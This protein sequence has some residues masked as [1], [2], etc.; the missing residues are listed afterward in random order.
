MRWRT[1]LSVVALVLVFAPTW[2]GEERLALLGRDAV[3][4]ARPVTIDPDD[5]A[6]RTVGAL[7]FLGGVSLHSPDRAFGGFSSMLVE[8]DRF[9]LLSDGGGIVRFRMGADWTPRAV[10][11]AELPDGPGSG[12]RRMDR[13]SESMTRD[14]VTGRTWVGFERY[15]AIWRYD[16][17]FTRAEGHAEPKAMADWSANSGAEAMVRLRGGGFL[18]FAEGYVVGEHAFAGLFFKGDPTAQKEPNMLFGYRAPTGFVPTDVVE[19]PDGDL[20]VVNR[21]I[22]L[23]HGWEG[24]LAIVSRADIRRRRI[25]AGREI[26]SLSRPV[27]QDNYEALAVVR[28]GDD[29]ILW[30]ASDDNQSALQQSLLLK[31]RLNLPAKGPEREKPASR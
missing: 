11:F 30:I 18:V 13:D 26:A 3:M 24:K 27:L 10:R 20:L 21:T 9:T 5:P 29:M 22:S 19:L 15:N 28:E 8:G 17:D 25:V 2:S 23:L 16:R 4:T 6:R 12:W 31:F 14:P 7:T 1:P